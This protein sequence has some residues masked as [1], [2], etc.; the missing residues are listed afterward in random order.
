MARQDTD[1]RRAFVLA[2][3]LPS[4]A[5]AS[6]WPEVALPDGTKAADVASHMIY[7]G[8][9]MHGQVFTSAM[10]AG[11][12]VKYYRGLWGKQSVLTTVDGWQIVGHKEGDFF[13][14]VQI[15]A[16]GGGSRGDIGVTRIPKEKVTVEL[17]KGV[18]HPANTVVFNDI[19]YPDDPTP[20]RT[21]AM[22][23]SLSV[24]Q[25]ASFYRDQFIASGW[26]PS[27]V[28]PCATSAPACVMSYEKGDR[29]LTL[30]LNRNGARSDIVINMMGEGVTQ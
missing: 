13:V 17:G 7:N 16:E 26:K 2:A 15:R 8:T 19:A 25:N 21:V 22:T 11:D 4:L 6:G 28:S 18:P 24:Q 12:V 30:M 10:N 9:D 1:R 27:Q 20:A 23:N 14:T 5:A 3:M 29:K